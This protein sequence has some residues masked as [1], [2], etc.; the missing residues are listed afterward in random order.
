MPKIAAMAH[1]AA[2]VASQSFDLRPTASEDLYDRMS[3]IFDGT[4]WIVNYK[5]G[6]SLYS[7]PFLSSPLSGPR[8]GQN[9]SSQD[10]AGAVG[11]RWG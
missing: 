6:Q 4:L 3:L 7:E 10:N 5:I 1:P 8:P 9:I 11:S 2:P